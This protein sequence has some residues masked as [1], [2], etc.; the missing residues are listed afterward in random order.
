M[1][2]SRKKQND[3]S[4]TRWIA[5]Q[6]WHSWFAWYPVYLNEDAW[7]WLCNVDRRRTETE[8]IPGAGIFGGTA[9]CGGFY[10]YRAQPYTGETP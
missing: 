3:A 6:E 2:W 4:F 5:S 9:M 1:I 10:I 8:F 7:A